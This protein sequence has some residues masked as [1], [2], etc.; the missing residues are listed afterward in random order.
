MKDVTCNIL[1]LEARRGI[2]D[3]IMKSPGLHIREISRRLEIPFTTLQYHL[4][5]LEK[6]ELVKAKEDGK[7][8]RYYV[9]FKFGRKEKDVVDLLRKK[10]T[11]SMI[12]Y[13]L[14]FIVCS[15]IELSKSLEKHP[16]TIEF[17]LKKM[18]KMGII[19]QVK[20]EYGVVKL[21]F[22]PYEVEHIPEGNEK[23]YCLVDPYFIYDLLVIHKESVLED[24][25]FRHIFEYIEFSVETGIPEKIS[26]PR[27]TID[28]LANI[29]WSMFPPSFRA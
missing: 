27:D 4:R 24:E 1:E 7:Y 17:H 2:Y 19:K 14:S 21:D 28:V 18:E 23:I 6:R 5:F 16:T 3:F 13:F 25:E 9:S 12:F 8:T 29:F 15:Q 11:R 10:T 20:S 26:S 22:I